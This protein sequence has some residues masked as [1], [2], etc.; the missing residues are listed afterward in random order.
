MQR[1]YTEEEKKSDIDGL[2]RL[3]DAWKNTAIESIPKPI[4]SDFT[5]KQFHDMCCMFCEVK[6]WSSHGVHKDLDWICCDKCY[7][8]L[9]P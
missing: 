3:A 7:Q 2:K 5:K 4:K 8:E 9:S 1:D 6:I